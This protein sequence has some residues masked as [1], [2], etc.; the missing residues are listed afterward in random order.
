MEYEQL[1][2]VDANPNVPRHL[3]IEAL[4]HR[5]RLKERKSFDFG[6]LPLR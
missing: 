3:L 1:I 2:E 5:L 4:L 6:I